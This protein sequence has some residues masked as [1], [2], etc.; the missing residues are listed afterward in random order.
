MS[1][2]NIY[3]VKQFLSHSQRFPTLKSDPSYLVYMGPTLQL[4]TCLV[5]SIIDMSD[6]SSICLSK[7][8]QFM[9]N[10]KVRSVPNS[11]IS[12]LAI[13]TLSG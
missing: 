12:I 6:I 8:R 4:I 11:R 7:G 10:P 2:K 9:Q 13:A 1:I 5:W 3:N